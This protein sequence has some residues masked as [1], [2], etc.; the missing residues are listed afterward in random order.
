[1]MKI[2]EIYKIKVQIFQSSF[3]LTHF[4]IQ[5]VRRDKFES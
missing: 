5:Q 2:N 1:M 4:L 3:I